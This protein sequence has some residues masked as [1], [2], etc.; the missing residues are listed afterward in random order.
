MQI[1]PD[2]LFSCYIKAERLK[3][4]WE[5]EEEE[6]LKQTSVAAEPKS[7]RFTSLKVESHL[8]SDQHKRLT[9]TLS[10]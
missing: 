5:E 3:K 8:C 2:T 9:T 4:K 7:T 6:R 10:V 1:C